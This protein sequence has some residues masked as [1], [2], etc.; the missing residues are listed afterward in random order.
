MITIGT[1]ATALFLAATVLV[2]VL[3]FTLLWI[4]SLIFFAYLLSVAISNRPYP[5]IHIDSRNRADFKFKD[6]TVVQSIMTKHRNGTLGGGAG[7]VRL[8]VRPCMIASAKGQYMGTHRTAKLIDERAYEIMRRDGPYTGGL[9]F[10]RSWL[11]TNDCLDPDVSTPCLPSTMGSIVGSVFE[12]KPT[13]APTPPSTPIRPSGFPEV[14]HRSKTP[15]SAFARAREQ[16]KKDGRRPLHVPV[17]QSAVDVASAVDD[18]LQRQVSEENKQ[19]LSHEREQDRQDILLQKV[20]QARQRRVAELTAADHAPAPTRTKSLDDIHATTPS[21]GAWLSER[22]AAAD[23]ESRRGKHNHRLRFA[24]VTPQDVHVY[25]SAPASLKRPPLALP[26]PDLSDPGVISLGEFKDGTSGGLLKDESED[27]EPEEGTPEDIRQPFLSS[28]PHKRPLCRVDAASPALFVIVKPSGRRAQPNR[29]HQSPLPSTLT[30]TTTIHTDHTD[31]HHHTHHTSTTPNIHPRRRFELYARAGASSLPLRRSQSQS[32]PR[33]RLRPQPQGEEVPPAGS[34]RARRGLRP[35]GSVRLCSTQRI[36]ASSPPVFPAQSPPES[37]SDPESQSHPYSKVNEHA[38]ADAYI[39]PLPL[40][41]TWL[42]SPLDHLLRSGSSP[43]FNAAEGAVEGFIRGTADASETDVARATLLLVCVAREVLVRCGLGSVGRGGGDEAGV[44]DG[45]E[46]FYTDFLALY[47]AIS[48]SHPLFDALLLAPTSMRYAVDYRRLLWCDYGRVVR[49]L[50][51]HHIVLAVGSGGGRL[52]DWLWPVERSARMVAAYFGALVGSPGRIEG[53]VR[54]LAIHHVASDIWS[55]L[56]AGAET[57][58]DDLSEKHLRAVV[59]QGDGTTVKEV[60][61]YRQVEGGEFVPPP[62]CFEA[63]GPWREKRAEEVGRMLG[64]EWGERLK[65]VVLGDS[66]CLGFILQERQYR[67]FGGMR[68]S[69]GSDR[70]KYTVGH[71]ITVDVLVLVLLVH[72]VLAST[73]EH[74]VLPPRDGTFIAGVESDHRERQ[75]QGIGV[76]NTGEQPR[77]SCCTVAHAKAAD[78]PKLTFE[79]QLMGD[80][81]LRNAWFQKILMHAQLKPSGPSFARHGSTWTLIAKGG[82]LMQNRQ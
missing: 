25:E 49:T 65:G 2:T 4:I 37:R 54:L 15:K 71:D 67:T 66:F 68:G 19:R 40:V 24:K 14:Q 12:R 44:V 9:D 7:V 72:G 29:G 64:K 51:T 82:N 55:D 38:D 3:V 46:K 75:K 80:L 39:S 63:G 13:T 41:R 31:P 78:G 59:E 16:A 35:C 30:S 36:P 8:D 79:R 26:P 5:T 20:A 48:F 73:C 17:V 28:H 74:L 61:R 56:R 6:D 53:F 11:R 23:L 22:A 50:R 21:K 70:T 69:Y 58:D 76:L 1:D 43:V 52:G 62:A 32:R 60:L 34:E 47:D 18:A 57:D 27:P 42:T 81:P 33:L 77:E 10:S 45:A